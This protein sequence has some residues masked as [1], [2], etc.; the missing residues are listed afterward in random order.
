MKKLWLTVFLSG[1]VAALAAGGVLHL[2]GLPGW[3]DAVWAAATAAAVLPALWWVISAL[4]ARRLG[5]DAIAVLA[6][7]GTL[8]VQEY[9]AGALIAVMLSTGRVLEEYALARAGRDL[10]ALYERAPRWAHR[11]E[12]GVPK[13]VDVA[14]VRRGDLLAVPAGEM[15]PVDGVVAGHTAVLDESALTGESMPVEYP[16]G[17]S[18]RSGVVNAGSAFDLRATGTAEESTYAGVVRLARETEA[19]SAPVVRLADRFAAWFLP[20]TLVIAGLAWALSGDLVRAVAVLVV[21][22]PCPLLLAAPAAIA[23]GLSRT[24]RHGVVVKGGGALESLGRARTLVL[25]KT[26]TLTEGRP[27]VLDVVPAPGYAA[28]EVLSLAAAVD[29]VS[30]HVLATAIVHAAEARGLDGV[31]AAGV[32]ERPGSGTEG[33]VG[34]RLVRVGKLP[35]SAVPADTDATGDP[36]ATGIADPAA[37]GT[38]D[39]AATDAPRTDAPRTDSGWVA[40]QRARAALDS[41]ITVWITVD[42]VVAGVV[43]LRDAVRADASRTLRRLRTAGIDRVVM[44]TGDRAE[45]AQGVAAVLGVDDVLAERSPAGKV[46]GVREEAERAPTVMVG[47]GV[48][49]A[50][51]LAAAQVGVA[52]GARGSAASTQAAD[53]VLTTDRLDRLA[54]AMDV[55]R[56]ARRIAVESAGVGIGLS[57]LA[58][59]FAAF[60]FLP[61]AA[62]ALLQ[63]AI[64]VA[65]ILNALRAL[66]PGRGTRL[67]V[68]RP[69]GELLQRFD[70][71]HATLR[72]ALELLREAADALDGPPRTALTLLR[73]VH[74]ALDTEIMPHEQEEEQRL[75]PALTRLLGD[76]EATVTMSR[77]H[78]EIG[79]LADR[80][81][82]HLELAGED[83]PRPEQRD[84]LRA[85]LY[86]LH[87]VLTLHFAQEEEAYFSLAGHAD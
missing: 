44:L 12:D 49:D 8:V 19:G 7:V 36:A 3:G 75:Y 66:A 55:A 41:A 61:P 69:T 35:A 50:P 25:D 63:E 62:G 56:R 53:V 68:D 32:R 80:L 38:A 28:D 5:V 31:T 45:V 47:D 29:R 70:Q 73:R 48:N 10:T 14:A 71:E 64:D 20:A 1:T 84:D 42:G 17:E 46:E 23:S 74:D 72:P 30:S 4:R 13:R 77:A 82:R 76:P 86:G 40:A 79:R 43:L 58:M 21:A 83:G 11:Y 87:A 37:T 57:L 78:A 60:G 54:D 81:A 34:G 18:V 67:R 26:G 85:C 33:T 27:Q 2:A 39:P 24:A 22:T 9:L 59:A 15:V 6:L 51:A 52:M 65:V 16:E